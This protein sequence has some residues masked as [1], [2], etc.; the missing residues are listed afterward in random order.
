MIRENEHLSEAEIQ[1]YAFDTD[2]RVK[3]HLEVCEACSLKVANY[4][5]IFDGVKNEEPAAFDFVVRDFVLATLPARNAPEKPDHLWSVLVVLGG[6]VMLTA[7][8]VLFKLAASAV[9]AI[10][11]WLMVIAACFILLYQLGEPVM[12]HRKK[13]RLLQKI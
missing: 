10:G 8:Y 7:G 13:M 4:R 12:E 11:L 1:T 3:A 9:S 6:L 2:D 5:L